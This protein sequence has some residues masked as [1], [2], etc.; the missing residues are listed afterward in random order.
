[1]SAH[2][3]QIK[4]TL[5][6]FCAA[7]KTNDAA[8]VGGFFAEDGSLINPFGQRAD[9]RPAVVAMY[10]EYFKGMLGGTST[11]ID[12]TGVRPIEQ[13]HAF[14]DGEQSVTAANG[15]VVLAVH[16]ATLFRRGDDGWSIVD[17]RPY[18]FAAIPG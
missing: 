10:S 12:L 18:S 6:R 15:D 2:F 13:D 3:D 4:S 14:A 8:T 1:M 11:T 9:G 16:F 7:W 17:S 5:D